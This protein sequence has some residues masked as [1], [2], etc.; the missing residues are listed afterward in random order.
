[1]V[2]NILTPELDEDSIQHLLPVA[3]LLKLNIDKLYMVAATNMT[4][5]FTVE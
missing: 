1:M 4:D 5:M 2:W 3:E